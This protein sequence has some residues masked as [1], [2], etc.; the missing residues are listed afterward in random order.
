[1]RH[2]RSRSGVV[3]LEVLVALAILGAIGASAAVLATDAA[4][5]VHRA[6]RAEDEIRR[7]SALLEVV[8]LWPRDDLDRHIGTRA[9]GDFMMEV[10]RP[11]ASL[12][13]VVLRD[14]LR[15]VTLVGTS[16]FRAP[17]AASEGAGAH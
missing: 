3:L 1:M 2:N 7:A 4:N 9:Q 13:T 10:A 14:S 8:S 5:V 12:Y 16:L 15:R 11:T 6:Q 17:A